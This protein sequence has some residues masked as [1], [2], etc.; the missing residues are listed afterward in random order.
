MK[1]MPRM[2]PRKLMDPE[3][4]AVAHIPNDDPDEIFILEVVNMPEDMGPMYFMAMDG[5]PGFSHSI[6]RAEMYPGKEAAVKRLEWTA[7]NDIIDA[8]PMQ[9]KTSSTQL[10]V[11]ELKFYT[12]DPDT[13]QIVTPG[14]T[15]GYVN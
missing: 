10:K 9:L 2:R 14:I 12:V 7:E 8:L 3:D 1:Q 15:S 13:Q 4:T 5:H 11:K 6:L